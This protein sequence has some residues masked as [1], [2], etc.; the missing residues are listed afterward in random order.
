MRRVALFIGTNLAVLLLLSIVCR[1]FGLDQ[2][3]AARGY[4]GLGGLLAYDA[5]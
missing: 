5:V 2:M 1:L 4:G 3:A